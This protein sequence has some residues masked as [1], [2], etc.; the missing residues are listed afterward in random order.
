MSNMQEICKIIGISSNHLKKGIK[1]NDI[2]K[3]VNK[4]EQIKDFLSSNCAKIATFEK[5]STKNKRFWNDRRHITYTVPVS[6]KPTEVEFLKIDSN[7][8]FIER[9]ITYQKYI[10]NQDI[11]Y[12]EYCNQFPIGNKKENVDIRICKNKKIKYIELKVLDSSDSPSADSPIFAIVESIKN[13][14]LTADR[15]NID[16]LIVLAPDSYWIKFKNMIPL[17]ELLINEL[18]K[19]IPTEISLKKIN[20]TPEDF[21]QIDKIFKDYIYENTKKEGEKFKSDKFLIE[22]AEK[23]EAC[24]NAGREKQYDYTIKRISLP[25][26][27]ENKDLKNNECIKQLLNWTDVTPVHI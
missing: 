4:V 11:D 2:Y 13:Y 17:A 12:P 24:K 10:N 25:E 23:T 14:Y 27:F 18:K 7:E 15:C 22:W 19:V 3:I 5:W 6:K 26:I 16:E 20:F 9:L 1:Y 21:E 8:L